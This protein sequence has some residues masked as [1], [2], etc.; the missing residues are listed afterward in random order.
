MCIVQRRSWL[1]PEFVTQIID[2]TVTSD[3]DTSS[4]SSDG[5]DSDS[6]GDDEDDDAEVQ[7]TKDVLLFV[8]HDVSLKYVNWIVVILTREIQDKQPPIPFHLQVPVDTY[9]LKHNHFLDTVRQVYGA[10]FPDTFQRWSHTLNSWI[11]TSIQ[12]GILLS[13]RF[14]FAAFPGVS[15]YY[16]DRWVWPLTRAVRKDRPDP[17]HEDGVFAVDHTF[18]NARPEVAATRLESARARYLQFCGRPY[19]V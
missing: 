4:D 18:G 12:E 15:C 3:D 16:R 2:L 13:Y 19:N 17:C 11:D 8:W 7:V 5:D 10:D 1:T 14:A 6:D 9:Q